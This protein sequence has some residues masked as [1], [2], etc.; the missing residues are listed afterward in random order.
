MIAEVNLPMPEV[1]CSSIN[2]S[3]EDYEF[4]SPHAFY[5]HLEKSNQL[6]IKYTSGSL[7]AGSGWGVDER[8][9][10]VLV[11][12]ILKNNSDAAIK[13]DEMKQ[14]DAIAA[15]G[16]SRMQDIEKLTKW[17]IKSN[18]DP[19]DPKNADLINLI[20]SITDTEGF[21]QSFDGLKLPEHFRLD[22]MT[23][24]FNFAT[25]HEIESNKRYK[26]ISL[27]SQDVPEF[28]GLKLLPN[29][30][31]FV[32]RDTFD[33]YEKRK[34]KENNLEDMSDDDMEDTR[35]SGKGSR[36][37]KNEVEEARMAGM[38]HVR[39][40]RQQILQQF[41]FIRNQKTLADMV[42]EEQVPDIK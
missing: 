33:L 2:Y 1:N 10:T 21:S 28:R 4:A 29:Q 5:M 37:I 13:N 8:D 14:Y 24:E 31:R 32:K 27:R 39:K 38:R 26:L 22:Q 23:H 11:P 35:R 6:E 7:K 25:E 30:E 15:L 16:V 17:I 41:K 40:I 19:N 3:L 18:L 20:K 42:I 36:D 9:G 34:M 12:P